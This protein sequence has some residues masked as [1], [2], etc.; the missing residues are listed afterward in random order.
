LSSEDGSV[1]EKHHAVS[2]D[3]IWKHIPIY[4]CTNDLLYAGPM[5]KLPRIAGGGLVETFKNMAR[6]IY[7][8][9][10]EITLCGK[11]QLTSFKYVEEYVRGKFGEV[12]ITNFY[13]IGDNPRVDIKGANGARWRSI[14]VRSGLFKGKGNDEGNPAMY[15]VEDFQE[16]VRLI[17]ELE[18][19]DCGGGM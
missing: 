10:P 1:V 3:G 6:L 19:I 15:V 12:E 16:A 8:R 9:E 13:M 4:C 18:G 17:F 2:K 14:L 7:G 5:I 11:P